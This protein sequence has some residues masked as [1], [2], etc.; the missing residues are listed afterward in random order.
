[1]VTRSW[2]AGMVI[3]FILSGSLTSHSVSW[4]SSFFPSFCQAYKAVGFSEPLPPPWKHTLNML[5]LKWPVYVVIYVHKY[6]YVMLI[7]IHGPYWMVSVCWDN[8]VGLSFSI[9]QDSWWPEK[10]G[11]CWALN[12]DVAALAT[13]TNHG[14]EK[15]SQIM[16]YKYLV[17]FHW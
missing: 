11:C 15:L 17:Q 12:W 6:V 7:D 3:S 1:M 2:R 14:L 4:W 9:W 13:L 16:Y 5:I 8:S 10:P